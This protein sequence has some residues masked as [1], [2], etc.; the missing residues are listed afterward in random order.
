VDYKNTKI[1]QYHKE[2][3]ALRTETTINNTRDF[4]INKG[5]HHL[6]ALRKI[7]FQANRRLLDVQRLS[8]DCWI[9]EDAFRQ[10]NEP[11]V[12]EGQRASALRFADPL[13][14]ALFSALLL[15]RL[16][17]RGF[18]NRELRDHW[19]PLIGKASQS[20]TPGQMTYHLRRLRLHGLIERVP[21]SHRYRVTDQGWRTILFCTRCHNRLL[22][23]G[24]AQLL[25]EE[26]A[27]GTIL[28]RRFDQLD[29]A[30]ERWLQEQNFAA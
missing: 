9:G 5:L 6:P 3:R 18:S 25:P 16:L 24:L 14:Q 7:G 1:K 4:Q 10:V 19:A 21:K 27:P 12:V 28:R 26:A 29:E 15:F 23:P 8:H 17:P 22:R 2:G 13:V 30:I 11:A 20:I